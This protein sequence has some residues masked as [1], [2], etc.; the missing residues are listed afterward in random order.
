MK[1]LG[2]GGR[3]VAWAV[4]AFGAFLSLLGLV[5]SA[6]LIAEWWGG[7]GLLVALLLAPAAFALAPWAALLANGAPGLLIANYGGM[8]LI[9]GGASLLDFVCEHDVA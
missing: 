9:W 7:G 4:I 8:A 2:S 6:V 3:L 1:R 5:G